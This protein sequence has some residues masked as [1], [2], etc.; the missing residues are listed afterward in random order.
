MIELLLVVKLQITRTAGLRINDGN[1]RNESRIERRPRRPK[2]KT[3]FNKK[4]V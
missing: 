4:A 2:T 3:A 1:D